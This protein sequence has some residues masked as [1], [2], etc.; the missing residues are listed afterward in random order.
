MVHLRT[1]I[2]FKASLNLIKFKRRPLA[3]SIDLFV[4]SFLETLSM[5]VISTTGASLFGIP[6][7]ILLFVSQKGQFWAKPVL[8]HSLS[9]IVNIGRSIPFIILL[10]ALIPFTRFVVGSSIGTIAASVPLTIAAI[11]FWLDLFKGYY[12]KFHQVSF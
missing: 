5:V 2:R 7:G 10:V 11:P 9:L 12:Q 8:N 3:M 4:Q 6:L 1:M